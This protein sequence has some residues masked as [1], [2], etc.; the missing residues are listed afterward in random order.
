MDQDVFHGQEHD[1]INTNLERVIR[2][3][4]TLRANYEALLEA[5]A[6]REQIPLDVAIE[7]GIALDK[8]RAES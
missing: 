8:L 5:L 4:K 6:D 2:E 7:A 3:H 1:R